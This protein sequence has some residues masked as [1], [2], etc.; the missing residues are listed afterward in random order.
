[1]KSLYKPKNEPMRIAAF[2]SGKGSNLRKILEMRKKLGKE[3]P[4][5][6]V[7]VFTDVKDEEKCNARKIATEYGVKYCCNDIRDYYRSRGRSDRKDM[8]VRSEYDRETAKLLKGNRIDAVA[9]CGYTSITTGEIFH[10]FVTV[11]VHPADLRILDRNGKRLFAGCNGAQ[12]I[13]WLI[14]NNE[15]EMMATTHIVTEEVDGGPILMTSEAV[16]IDEKLSD[17]ENLER[18]KE[19]GDWKIYPETIKRLAQGRFMIDENGIALDVVEEKALLREGMRK[20][21]EKLSDEEVVKKSSAITKRL[22]QLEEY[23]KARTVMFY[24][25]INKEVKTEE[26]VKEALGAGKMAVVPVTDLE[27]GRIVPVRL[28]SLSSLKPGAYGILEPAGG[29]EVDEKGIELVIVPGLAFDSDC[30]RI[31]YGLGFYDRFLGKVKAKKVALAYEM[32]IVD[33]VLA[34][35]EDVPMDAIVTEERVIRRGA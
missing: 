33:R 9:M 16:R 20:L 24:M 22:L 28:A 35:E 29:R 30:N 31:G 25:G 6:V 15:R 2:M 17:T 19:L 11:N 12:C 1:M 23:R 21:R 32:Q 18:L 5:M 27:K 10:N 4:F 26:T 8:G 3:C 34:T 14:K 13:R 7:L